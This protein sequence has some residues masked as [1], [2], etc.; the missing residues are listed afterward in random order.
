VVPDEGWIV[1]MK[2]QIY[3]YHGGHGYDNSLKS[4]QAILVAKGPLFR[5][6]YVGSEPVP[7]TNVYSLIASVLGLS[8]QAPHNNT[9]NLHSLLFNNNDT[10]TTT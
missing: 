5:S 6:G 4:M 8:L 2:D 3:D 9:V 10:T 7:N 1:T